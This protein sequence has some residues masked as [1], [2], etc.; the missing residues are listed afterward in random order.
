MSWLKKLIPNKIKKCFASAGVGKSLPPTYNSEAIKELQEYY[1]NIKSSGRYKGDGR[2]LE[3]ELNGLKSLISALKSTS[4]TIDDLKIIERGNEI[5]SAPNLPHFSGMHKKHECTTKMAKIAGIE[6]EKRGVIS[7]LSNRLTKNFMAGDGGFAAKD[8]THEMEKYP[9]DPKI[10]IVQVHL[11][12][13]LN[14]INKIAN[15]IRPSDEELQSTIDAAD[16]MTKAFGLDA[17]M[18]EWQQEKPALMA[19]AYQVRNMHIPEMKIIAENL[20]SAHSPNRE[21]DTPAGERDVSL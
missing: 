20:A 8:L 13:M 10:Q 17:P 16:A 11:K 3:G 9:D 7:M 4:P 21:I 6:L 2:Y 18:E 19:L 5:I 15:D 12:N 1:N 14:G